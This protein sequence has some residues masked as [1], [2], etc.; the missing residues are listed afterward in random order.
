MTVAFERIG[1]RKEVCAGDS[2]LVSAHPVA[3][4]VGLEVF[5]DG[6]NAFDVA[7]AAAFTLGVVE[8]YASGIG[9]V[10]LAIVHD[11]QGLTVLDGGPVAPA[12]LDIGRYRLAPGGIDTDL[13]GWPKVEGDANVM[14][15]TSVCVPSMV[16]LARALYQRGGSLPWDRLLRPAIALAEGYAVDWL[17]A[18]NILHEQETLSRFPSTSA[19]L[20]PRGR[21]PSYSL[22]STGGSVL[23][24]SD[25]AS[26]LRELAA[27]GG[28]TFY[29]GEIA[30]RLA[31]YI[32]SHGGFLQPDDLFR[33]QVRSSSPHR[34]AFRGADVWVPNG[35]NG[36]PTIAEILWLYHLLA[37][38]E[39]EW[40]SVADLVAWIKAARLAF[41]DRL[42]TTGH[43]GD[44]A[45]IGTREHAM[46]RLRGT[47]SPIARSPHDDS[48]TY[49]AVVDGQGNA[50]SMNLTLLS[51]WGSK[52]IASGLGILLNNGMMWFDPRP[53][54]PNGMA[55]GARPL[56]NMAP[57]VVTRD[58]EPT[59]LLGASGGRRIIG[60]VAQI[61]NNMLHFGLGAQEA[62]EAPRL[63][64]STVPVLADSRLGLDT[65]AQVE[66]MA[67]VPLAYGLPRLGGHDFSS[68]CALLRSMGKTWTAG[69]DP[70]GI[71]SAACWWGKG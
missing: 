39:A 2:I 58:G 45:A 50:V 49:L 43:R 64:L 31:D 65:L 28:D 30:Q 44:M 61:L 63:E 15:A 3:T 38:R 34:V 32:R 29:H 59:A 8:P 27:H 57:V 1:L 48:T 56:A 35:F 16:A 17:L 9:G 41:H 14:G 7:I 5:R 11:S 51:R 40:A 26:T 22:D 18:L 68:P 53:E 4:A 36:G 55:P 21:V 71:G 37:P 42:T 12:N 70:M 62:I 10:G 13:F 6:G 66:K 23:L 67:E 52:L 46:Q 60:A 54:S 69:M 25:L 24:Q 33:Y 19:V 20:L 47:T